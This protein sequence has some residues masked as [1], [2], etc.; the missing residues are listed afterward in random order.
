MKSAG[1]CIGASNIG[2][3]ITEKAGEKISILM[4]K[5]V[6]HDGN[7]KKVLSQIIKDEKINKVEKVIIT[8]RKIRKSINLSSISEPEAVE[9][10]YQYKKEKHGD[11]NLIISAGGETFMVYEID[12]NGKIIDVFTGNKCAS[13][14]GEFFLQQIKRMGLSLDEAVDIVDTDSSY[15]LSGRCSVFCKSDC[16]HALNK[17]TPK[18]SV[19]AGLCEMMAG[20]IS[21]LLKKTEYKSVIVIGGTTENKIMIDYL[22]EKI[23]TIVVPDYAL[24]FEAF[25]AA[26]W[27]YEHDVKKLEEEHLYAEDSSSFTFLPKLEEF[28]KMVSFREIE[29][30]LVNIEDEYILGLDVGST[31]TKAVLLNRVTNAI[32]A[33]C[34]LRTNGDPVG[35]AREC[36]K[37]ISL[38]IDGKKVKITGL[39]VTGSGRQIAGIHA[40]TK[41]VINEIIAHAAAAV[42]F[43]K[44]VDTIFEIGGQDAKYTYITNGVASDYAMNEACSA[45][46]GSFLEEA[47]KESLDISTLEIEGIAM[48]SKRPP[49]FSDQCAAFISSDIKSAI[50]EGISTEDITAGLVYSICLNY[51]NRVKGNRPVG[52]KVFM[53]GGVC[54]NKAV[55]IAM[56]AITGNQIVVPPE[57]GL[58]GA[59]GVALEVKNKLSLGLLEKGNFDLE[60]LADR[61]VIYKDIFTCAGGKEKCDR[62]CNIRRIEVAGKNYPFG[63]ACNMYYN[64]VNNK[65]ESD[66]EFLNLVKMREKFVFEDYSVNYAKRKEPIKNKKIG[67]NR[68]LLVNTLY[69]LYYNFFYS[70]GYDIVLS[71]NIDQSGIDKKGSNFCYPVEIA[72]GALADLL[73]RDVEYIFLPHLKSIPVENGNDVQ[74][75]CPLVQAEPY[76]LGSAF[77]ELDKKQVI[78]TVIDFDG[79]YEKGEEAFIEIGEKLGVSETAAKDAFYTAVAAQKAFHKRCSAEGERALEEIN[80]NGDIG[81]IL[82]GRAYNAFT[83][84]ANMGIPHKFATRGYMI[85]PVEF[86]PAKEEEN[87]NNMYWATGQIIMKGAKYIKD[88]DNLYGV[89]IS[90]FSCGPDSFVVSYFRKEMD[91]KPSLMLELDSH[92]ADAGVDTRIEAF[93]DVVKSYIEINKDKEK[94]TEE[95]FKPAETFMKGKEMYVISSEGVEYSLRDSKVH[96]YIPTLDEFGSKLLAATF[97]HNGY[98]ASTAMP[99]GE[100]EIKTGRTYSFCKECLP[101]TLTI[102]TLMNYI[103][104]RKNEDDI[105]VYF[106]PETSGPCRF[107]QYNVLMKDIIEKNQIRNVTLLSLSSENSYA[108]MGTPFTLRAWYSAIITDVMDEIKSSIMVLAKDKTKAMEIYGEVARDIE[109]SIELEKWRDIKKTFKKCA[110]KLAEIERIKDIHD[111]PK[112]ALVGE[113]YV[114]RDDFSRQNIVGKLAEKGII[115]RVAPITEWFYYTDYLVKHR[116]SK[117]STFKERIKIFI[118]GFF[119]SSFEKTIKEIFK[120]TD[121]YEMRM[122]DVERMIRNV[123]DI[124]SPNL[125]GEAI[126]TVGT[127]ITE[128]AEESDGI[129][130][131]SPFGCM[132]SRIAEA[133]INGKMNEIKESIAEDKDFVKKVMEHY[134]SLPFLNIETDGNPFPQI[135][136][137]KL[138]TFCLQVE[139]LHGYIK[140][141]RKEM[142]T[143]K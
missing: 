103:K 56:A 133:V 69:P 100:K 26:L 22:R 121:L 75:I 66:T 136:E 90:N 27:G 117:K 32:S 20:K 49:N 39:G 84:K 52:K 16:T 101:L 115:T 125:T 28:K 50:Q 42:Y 19:V 14:T 134:P 132:P 109:K 79:G 89:Y 5:S 60:E 113:I 118:T 34:Y 11:A 98:N 127:A 17:G 108:G 43:D 138:E 61:E 47:A 82:F 124:I 87:Y 119:K 73:K 57:P 58:M 131:V 46:T 13:G 10:A 137:A 114:R 68:S 71:E 53:Q 139:R 129:I 140:Q 110:E 8:G 2:F 116:L 21:E 80:K 40:V 4:S 107:G 29:K 97:R 6:S 76:Y 112:V 142:E 96:I 135:V 33:D 23:G 120:A 59:F 92:T 72:H 83:K 81:I 44:D 70:L 88:K 95:I 35:A 123:E 55:P 94:K 104:E 7:P 111:V 122:I 78:N 105:I 126:L 93:L 24:T 45:G 41:G 74:T 38:K 106:M 36:Y 25:G 31:T 128:V 86:L 62:K 51:I 99:P 64:I 48:K 9:Y 3:V 65:K 37:N 63:G 91:K 141:V 1:I 85:I 130:S 12:H 77:G 67:I 18:E 102:G 54:Y 143:I 15:K 30:E